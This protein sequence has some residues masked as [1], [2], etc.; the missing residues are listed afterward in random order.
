MNSLNKE[1]EIL[2]RKHFSFLHTNYGMDLVDT[3]TEVC[4][5][6]QSFVSWLEIWYD[7]SSLYID[8]GIM[9][10]DVK[11]S[12]R[13]IKMLKTGEAKT[14]TY[15]ASTVVALEKGLRRLASYVMAYC[16]EALKGDIVFFREVRQKKEDIDAEI[17]VKNLILSIELHAKEAWHRKDYARV[18]EIYAPYRHNLTLV[19]KKG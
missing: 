3:M 4:I 12:L 19:Q 14:V 10:S 16:D 8:I 13:A 7:R 5:R 17:A 11:E 15:M 18:V 9:D 1:F 2:A 6:Y